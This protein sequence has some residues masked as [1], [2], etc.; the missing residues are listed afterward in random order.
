MYAQVD[1]LATGARTSS[2]LAE[3]FKFF[4]THENSYNVYYKHHFIR[5]FLYMD[6]LFLVY[7]HMKTRTEESKFSVFEEKQKF[8]FEE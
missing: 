8:T 5:C 4:R 7:D 3:F 1:Y 6:D 2:L